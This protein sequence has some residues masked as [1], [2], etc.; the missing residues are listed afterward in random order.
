VR[1]ALTGITGV[2]SAEVTYPNKAVVKVQKGK[3]K[4]DD[5]I[6]AL[7]KVGYTAKVKT[8]KDS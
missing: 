8:D 3:V 6:K 2:T 7:K 1:S 5:L 4:N